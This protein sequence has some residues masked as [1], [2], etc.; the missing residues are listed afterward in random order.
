MQRA[1]TSAPVPVQQRIAPGQQQNVDRGRSITAVTAA[2][3]FHAQAMSRDHAL[4]FQVVQRD[5]AAVHEAAEM[6]VIGRAQ[7]AALQIMDEQ[8]VD[9]VQSQTAYDI[10]TDRRIASRE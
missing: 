6:A 7:I 1:I 5:Q 2:T 3:S 9:P 8:D 4:R 10:S